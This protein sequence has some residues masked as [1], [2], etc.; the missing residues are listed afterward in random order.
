MRL[1][2]AAGGS[3]TGE[4]GV[5]L[6]K[7]DFLGWIFDET[8]LAVMGR[9]KAAFNAGENYNPCKAFPTHKG[10]GE[11]SQAHVAKVTAAIG[12]DLYV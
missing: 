4:H 5:G 10:C 1:C 8:D 3:I 12:A 6:E 11:L 2:V 9:L 7:R